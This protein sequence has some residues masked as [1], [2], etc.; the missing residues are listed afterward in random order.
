MYEFVFFFFSRLPSFLLISLISSS[1]S[2]TDLFI[3]LFLY[4]IY[5][6]VSK[7]I[8]ISLQLKSSF[9]EII[10]IARPLVQ[11]IVILLRSSSISVFIDSDVLSAILTL[12]HVLFAVVRENQ[13]NLKDIIYLL[14]L[15]LVALERTLSPPNK[16]LGS[17]KELLPSPQK[18]ERENQKSAQSK[19]SEI[20]KIIAGIFY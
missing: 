8:A 5:F 17:S 15:S 12:Q 19:I 20:I 16:S 14:R 6:L 11:L 13:T 4:L 9:S 1:S 18:R 2:E 3:Y 7:L 10:S